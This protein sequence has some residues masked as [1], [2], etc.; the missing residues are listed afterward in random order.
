MQTWEANRLF[1]DEKEATLFLG[2]LDSIF[3][4]SY[5]VVSS[6]R[7]SAQTCE[8][9]EPARSSVDTRVFSQGLY[10]SGVIGDRVNLRYVLCFGLCGSATVVSGRSASLGPVL[11][12]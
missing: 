10:L 11:A 8:R 9:T 4:F 7:G 1:A 6:R 12:A 5:A 3:L 2:A